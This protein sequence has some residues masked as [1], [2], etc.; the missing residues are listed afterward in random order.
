MLDDDGP[1][2]V[3]VDYC[4]VAEELETNDESDVGFAYCS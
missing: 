2:G 4:E 1:V 3:S